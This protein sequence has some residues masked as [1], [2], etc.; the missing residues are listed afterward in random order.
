MSSASSGRDTVLVTGGGGFLGRAI[1]ERLRSAGADVKCLQRSGDAVKG[2]TTIAGDIRDADAVTRAVADTSVVIHAAALAHVFDRA[3]AAPFTEVNE[4]GTEVVARASAAAG[5]QHLIL[6]SSVAVYGSSAGEAR[7][8]NACRP[9]TPYGVSKLAGESRAIEAVAGSRTRLTILRMATLYGERD[10]GNVQRLLRTLDGGRFVP[11][12]S[13][14]NRKSLLHVEDAARACVLPIGAP[15]EPIEIYNVASPA[16]Q[17]REVVAGLA[18][19]LGRR[20]PRWYVPS[21]AATA[22]AAIASAIFPSRGRQLRDS[23]SKWLADDVYPA[24]KFARRFSFHPEVPLHDGLRRQVEW[25][26]ACG[27]AAARR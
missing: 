12:G 6:I 20:V 13:G 16:V 1:V 11:V 4:H 21:V 14:S 23:V 15:G 24:D 22:P 17:M 26:R 8:D 27:K 25:W 7:E 2:A 18:A 19:A 3:A 9:S 10:R 5:V